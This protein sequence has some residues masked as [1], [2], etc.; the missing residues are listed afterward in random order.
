MQAVSYQRA[1]T[2]SEAIDLL[3]EGG[4][5]AR[6]LAGGTDIIVQARER[7]KTVDSL[8]DI[9]HIPELMTFSYNAADGLSVG[10]AA[11]LYRLYND[12]DIKTRYPALVEAMSVIGGIAIQGRASLGGNLCNSSPA[13][14]SLTSMMVL[15]A[16]AHVAGPNGERDVEVAEFFTGPGHN[17]MELG[18]FV[19]RIAFAAPAAASGAAWQRFIPRNEMDIAVV[20]CG[21]YIQLEGDTVVDARSRP[22]CGRGHAN[23][24]PGSSRGVD[25]A[26]DHGRDNRRRRGSVARGR[27]AH[28][29]YARL[30]AAAEAPRTRAHAADARHRSRTGPQLDASTDRI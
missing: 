29:R 13:G 27:H 8:V 5:N 11:E 19:T 26:S 2:I 20:N 3:R 28:R 22:R 16:V 23:H 14:D 17:V 25:R 6:V 30:G 7:A 9:K 21:S 15:G 4:E 1:S 10:A 18:E 12:D 24:G